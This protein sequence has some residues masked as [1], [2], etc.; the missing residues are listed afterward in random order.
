MREIGRE[1]TAKQ[2][3][4]EVHLVKEFEF[5]F[6]RMY[7]TIKPPVYSGGFIVQNAEKKYCFQLATNL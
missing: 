6:N 5:S 2:S 7:K 4:S 1:K 3:Q